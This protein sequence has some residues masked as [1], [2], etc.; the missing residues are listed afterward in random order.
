MNQTTLYVATS[1]QDISFADYK[2]LT[3]VYQPVIGCHA[4]VLYLTLAQETMFGSQKD[5][6]VKIERL[7][8]T[9]NIEMP[10]F[11]KAKQRL[12]GLNLLK[13]YWRK[14]SATLNFRLLPPLSANQFFQNPSFYNILQMQLTKEEIDYVAEMLAIEQPD[15]NLDDVE[16]LT[17]SFDEVYQTEF[18]Q[19]VNLH[20]YF[21]LASVNKILI[22]RQIDPK[23]YEP[24]VN[25]MLELLYYYKVANNQIAFIIFESIET[26]NRTK[27]FNFELFKAKLMA[28]YDQNLLTQATTKEQLTFRWNPSKQQNEIIDQQLAAKMQEMNQIEPVVYL[29]CYLNYQTT[30]TEEIVHV[31]RDLSL[32]LKLKRGVINCLIEFILIKNKNQF[33]CRYAWKIGQT[34]HKKQINTVQ[35]AMAYFKKVYHQTNVKNEF[36]AFVRQARNI[37]ASSQNYKLPIT[38]TIDE[39]I[40]ERTFAHEPNM[41]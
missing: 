22:Q 32:T 29:N 31:L 6:F 14:N 15:N 5:R 41:D 19:K 20:E 33:N 16:D 38:K 10:L 40:N 4:L 2:V 24:Y 36:Q 1:Q 30:L 11:Q 34:L 28:N 21:N 23:I 3:L 25:L 8:K 37:K 12:E 13:T 27:H 17:S 35:T 7:L 9:L 18:A 26:I 39:L